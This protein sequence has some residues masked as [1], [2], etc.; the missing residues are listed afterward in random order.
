MSLFQVLFVLFSASSAQRGPKRFQGKLSTTVKPEQ[1]N[2]KFGS[3]SKEYEDYEDYYDYYDYYYDDPLP[4][5]P[6]R[7]PVTT[8]KSQKQL[9]FTGK[10]SNIIKKHYKSSNTTFGQHHLIFSWANIS[11]IF[12]NPRL[13][14]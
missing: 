7:R 3:N 6:T 4:S 9:R 2:K 1:R 8:A 14:G 10:I 13:M 11:K 12:V 5:G